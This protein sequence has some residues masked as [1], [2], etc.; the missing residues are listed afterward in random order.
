MRTKGRAGLAAIPKDSKLK[1]LLRWPC[2][3]TLVPVPVI[4]IFVLPAA[5]TDCFLSLFLFLFTVGWYA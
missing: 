5:A 1:C 4:L 3:H 2:C